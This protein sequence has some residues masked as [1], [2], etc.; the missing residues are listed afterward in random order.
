MSKATLPDRWPVSRQ[1]RQPKYQKS[2]VK[3]GGKTPEKLTA[4]LDGVNL[5]RY[6]LAHEVSQAYLPKNRSAQSDYQYT[7]FA[8]FCPTYH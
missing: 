4:L 1:T 7:I 8:I 6:E 3:T 5:E 2:K